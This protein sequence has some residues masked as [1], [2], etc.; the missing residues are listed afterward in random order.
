MYKIPEKYET[1]F[2]IHKELL[3]TDMKG[4]TGDFCLIHMLYFYSLFSEKFIK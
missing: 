3:Q 4:N 2:V 1:I